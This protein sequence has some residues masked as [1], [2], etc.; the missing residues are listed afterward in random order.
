LLV[1]LVQSTTADGLRLDGVFQEPSTPLAAGLDVNAWCLVHGTGGNFYSS[2]L[3]ES[4][5]ERLL[6]LGCAVL[7]INT[8]GHDGISTAAASG[9]GGVRLGAAYEVVDDCRRDLAA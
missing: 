1:D 2:T 5:A 4:C 9:R 8:R 3:L 7:R 6:E